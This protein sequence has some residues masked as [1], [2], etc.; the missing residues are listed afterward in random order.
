MLKLHITATLYR[1]PSL[2]PLDHQS[3]VKF[4]QL[5]MT[6]FATWPELEC[7]PLLS[8]PLIFSLIMKEENYE[9]IL[10]RKNSNHPILTGNIIIRHLYYRESEITDDV[11]FAI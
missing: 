10:G 11:S 8:S 6:V 9:T 5:K 2:S 1:G 4:Y 7:I 3:S